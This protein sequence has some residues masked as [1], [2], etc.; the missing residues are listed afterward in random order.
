MT[1][2][3]IIGNEG[4][5][6]SRK[7]RAVLRYRRIPHRWMVKLGPEYLA[8]PKPAVDVIPVL[9]WHDE[10][11]A[12]RESM[13]DSTPQIQRLER[14]YPEH[15]LRHPDPALGFLDALIEDYADEWGT[16]Y[17][18]HYRWAGAADAD[19]A[20]PHLVRQANPWLPAAQIEQMGRMFAKR[21]IERLWVVG[22]N[23]GTAPMIEAGYRRL[24]GL[25]DTL[26]ATRQFLF[27]KRPAAADFGLYGQLS[28]LCL[29]DPTPA[30]IARETA[31]RV[32]AW[33]ERMED[34]SGWAAEDAQWADR[35]AVLPALL[36][37][38]REIGETYVPFL[39]ANAAA[40]EAG[41]EMVE[42][43]I[44]GQAWTQKTFPYQAKCLRWLREHYAGL[45][46]SDRS[47][48]RGVLEEAGAAALVQGL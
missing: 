30:R 13:V 17:M 31:P 32:L 5:P 9:V 11:G 7:M 42:C 39:I 8:P 18:F 3:T 29:F 47:W 24:L 27:G 23:P 10:S 35:A 28:Q 15:S 38:L 1:P 20:G 25:L 44:Q 43:L 14:E 46:E 33:V 21:Q 41:K 16:K 37:L 34:L 19:W 4:S 6:Y 40:K 22:S 26:V 48:L 36:P 2:L 45:G 12:M